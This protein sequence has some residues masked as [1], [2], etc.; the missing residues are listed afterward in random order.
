MNSLSLTSALDMVLPSHII[1]AKPGS[2]HD[3]FNRFPFTFSHRL[4]ELPIFEIS[5]LAKISEII[6]ASKQP[7]KFC[8]SHNSGVSAGS[9]FEE[10]HPKEQV[11]EAILQLR[12]SNSWIKLSA[13]NEVIPE[14]DHLAKQIILEL[15]NLTGIALSEEITW[16]GATIFLGSPNTVVPYHLDREVNFLFQIHGVKEVNIFNQ[17]DRSILTEEELELSCLG[18]RQL[19]YNHEQQQKASVYLLQPGT[20]VHHPIC[21]PHWVKNGNDINVMLSLS[22]H[23]RSFD[24]H[25]RVYKANFYLRKLGL[26]PT[27]PGKSRWR[28]N[29]KFLVMSDAIFPFVKNCIASTKTILQYCKA[30]K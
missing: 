2:F 15:E 18:A 14:F 10:L 11:A 6:L 16:C 7:E 4:A 9:K 25:S 27:P 23:M 22:F 20:G 3:S 30:K 19:N 28:D 8:C 29:I 13:L 5:N 12:E 21:A 1:D 17:D 26:K 24:V